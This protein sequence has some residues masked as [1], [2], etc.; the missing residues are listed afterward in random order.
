MA[1][2]GEREF[3]MKSKGKKIFLLTIGLVCIGVGSYRWGSYIFNAQQFQFFLDSKLSPTMHQAIKDAVYE[4]Y[5]ATLVEL[6]N[7]I[8]QTCPALQQVRIEQRA[9][10]TLYVYADSVEPYLCIGDRILTKNGL[11]VESTHFASSSLKSLPKIVQKDSL[12]MAAVTNEFKKWLLRLDSLV[13]ACYQVVWSDD[14]HIELKDKHAQ[15]ATILCSVDVVPDKNIRELC[16]RIIEEKAIDM[17]GTARGCWY[18][19]DIR[20]E[21]QIILCSRKGGACHG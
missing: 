19:T 13:F 7:K 20:F 8:Q 11:L 2:Y 10:N 3:G 21:K 17:Q 18:T 16:Q 6:G 15:A 14:Y 9:N 12:N 1:R 4:S 5:G